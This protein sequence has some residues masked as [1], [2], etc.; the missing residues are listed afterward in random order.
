MKYTKQE[1]SWMLYDAASSA[2]SLSISTTVPLYF[3]L[4]SSMSSGAAASRATAAWGGMTSAAL[5]VLAVLSPILGALADYQGMKKKLFAAFLI[6]GLASLAAI[7]TTANIVAFVALFIVARICYTAC[8]VFYDSMLTDVTEESRMDAIS[9]N[10]FAVGYIASCIPFVVS[11][12]LLLF[13][14]FGLSQLGAFRASFLLTAAW[15]GLLSIPLVRNLKHRFYTEA[16]AGSSLIGQA[17]QRLRVTMWKIRNN[18]TILYFIIAYFCYMDGVYTI[19]SMA[20]IYGKEVG[21][22]QNLMIVAL[23]VTQIVAFPCVMIT[24]RLAR[25]V[26]TISMLRFFIVCYILICILGFM[27]AHA[28]QFWALALS[29]GAVQGGIQTLSRSFFAQL[30]PKDESNE[31]FGFY[32][33]FG[34]FADFIGPLFITASAYLTGQSKYGILMLVTLFIVGFIF[35]GKTAKTMKADTKA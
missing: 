5:L 12:Y 31:Y 9:A 29:V 18:K 23:L 4:I 10:G 6:V 33:I 24:G 15:W 3:A 34:K 25:K 32:D 17:F 16:Q 35:L 14:P 11:I 27:M 20:T 8:N 21:I 26:N 30:I 22:E 13:L 28:W 1:L 7:N 19:I 2:F